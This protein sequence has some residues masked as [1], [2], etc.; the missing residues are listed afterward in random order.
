[1][2]IYDA[3]QRGQAFGQVTNAYIRVVNRAD[4]TELARYDLSED[5]STETAMIFGEVYRRDAEW[6]FRAVGSGL[7][8]WP[9]RHRRRLRGE[10]RMSTDPGGVSLS[11]VTLTKSAPSVSLSKG[12]GAHGHLRVNLNWTAKPAESAAAADS[13]RSCCRPAVR[14]GSTWISPRCTS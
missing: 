10:C 1:M 12:G 3:E 7:R 8:E 2:S 4:G 14:A 9:A 6:K 13:S 5:A 11:K